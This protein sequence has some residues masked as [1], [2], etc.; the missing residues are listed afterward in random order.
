VTP[1]AIVAALQGGTAT[2]ATWR[3]LEALVRQRVERAVHAPQDR[4]DAAQDVLYKFA[5]KA[6]RGELRI[7]GQSDEEVAGYISQM[8]RNGWHSSGRKSRRMT[9][10]E[11]T[12]AAAAVPSTADDDLD[13][14]RSARQGTELFGRVAEAAV[15]RTP[16][17]HREARRVAWRQVEELYFDDLTVDELVARDEALGPDAPGDALKR[18]ANRAMKQ[19]QRFREAMLAT[20]GELADRGAISAVERSRVERMVLELRRR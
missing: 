15:E 19:H 10:D 13:R 9:P 7:T 14:A 5:E 4:A 16:A 6:L 12:V 2:P 3:A 8:A 11:A 17:A 18:A 20:A 1:V